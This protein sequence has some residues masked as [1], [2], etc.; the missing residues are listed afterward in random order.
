MALVVELQIVGGQSRSIPTP[1]RPAEN[2]D[3][4]PTLYIP[5]GMSDENRAALREAAL[6][7]TDTL[8]SIAARARGSTAEAAENMY[9]FRH[10][11]GRDRRFGAG[12]VDA[13]QENLTEASASVSESV[14]QQFIAKIVADMASS[15]ARTKR[16]L[17]LNSG[18]S[19]N[20]GTNWFGVSVEQG[21]PWYYAVGSFL[22]SYGAYAFRASG[23]GVMIYYRMFI[24]DRYNWDVVEVE[25]EHVSKEVNVPASVEWIMDESEIE[26]AEDFM[27]GPNQPYFKETADGESYIVTDALMGSLVAT[28]DAD[29]FDVVGAGT[30]HW[31][32]L[33]E[34][35]RPDAA[36]RVLEQGRSR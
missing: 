36:P 25:G 23:G 28:G 20:A 34:G 10:G 7:W 32:R 15:D 8:G 6:E 22:M 30:I 5:E 24:Y 31:M 11:D 27:F 4:D 13:M 21:S 3:T 19:A 1:E 9:H 18:I 26:G 33:S 2:G 29:N 12:S 14:S 16:Y 35:E 17:T